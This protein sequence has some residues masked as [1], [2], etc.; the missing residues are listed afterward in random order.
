MVSTAS[1]PMTES[2]FEPLPSPYF[3]ETLLAELQRIWNSI[4]M[5]GGRS[6]V[7]KVEI[8]PEGAGH[9]LRG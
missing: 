6:L 9:E 4:G 3:S 7:A 5:V 1:T 8:F 2:W